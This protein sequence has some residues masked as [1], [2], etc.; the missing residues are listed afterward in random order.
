MELQNLL[1]SELQHEVVL[2]EKFLKRIPKD[3]MEWR[4]HKK[5]MSIR[6]LANHLAEIPSWITAT[7]EMDEMDMTDYKSPDFD[8]M[9]EILKVL[10]NNTSEAEAALRKPDKDYQKN[11]KMMQGGKVLMDMPKYSVLRMM[12]LNQL[13]HHR[14]QLGVYFRLLNISVPATYGPS[15]DEN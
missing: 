10:L 13:P 12:V 14:A 4:P 2:T 3:K 9:E 15:A 8:T 5:S 11:W 6:Q 1:I 7:M